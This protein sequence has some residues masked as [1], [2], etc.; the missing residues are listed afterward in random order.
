MEQKAKFFRNIIANLVLVAT[1]CVAIV[2]VSRV[3]VSS[4]VIV[5]PVREG[6]CANSVSIAITATRESSHIEAMLQVLAEKE[7]IATFFVSGS[8]VVENSA[9]LKQIHAHGH[10]IG[11][12][13]FF[14]V[15]LKSVGVDRLIDEIELTHKLVQEKTGVEMNVFM[16]PMQKFNEAMIDIARALGYTTILDTGTR[17]GNALDSSSVVDAVL[18]ELRGGAFIVL[19]AKEATFGALSL[20]VSGITSKNYN[21]V[22]IYAV[23]QNAQT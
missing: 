18:K 6:S 8:W 14:N 17:V 20:I 19:P 1:L 12:Y 11:N 9:M 5:E 21:V 15:S 23:L 7:V 4:A 16:P 13:G 2:F 22:P 3:P 10:H